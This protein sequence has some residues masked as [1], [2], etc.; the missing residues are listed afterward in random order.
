MKNKKENLMEIKNP[1]KLL[2]DKD[3]SWDDADIGKHDPNNP[4]CVCDQCQ[5]D[6]EY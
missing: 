1:V 6:M 4:C 5:D 3:L 2:D